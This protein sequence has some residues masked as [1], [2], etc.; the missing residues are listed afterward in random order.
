MESYFCGSMMAY[1]S[2]FISSFLAA[3]LI[4]FS[5]DAVVA[6][7]LVLGYN[8]FYTVLFA[9]AGNTL[10]GLSGYGLG[11]LG[12]W[13]WIEKYFKMN[14]DKVTKTMLRIKH[15]T[16]LAAFLTWL[17]FVGDIIAVAL[18]FMRAPFLKVLLF[19]TAGKLS[20]YLLIVYV[21]EKLF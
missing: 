19:M 3:T 18:G 5:S 15:Y 14:S 17:P 16:A 13:E 6:G 10:G 1:F 7:M 12:K 11:R 8:S 21:W 9:T 2:L 4:P 20:R